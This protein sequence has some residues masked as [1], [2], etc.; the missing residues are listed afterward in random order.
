MDIKK[1]VEK[2]FRNF[3]NVG[4]VAASQYCDPYEYR[5]TLL[6]ICNPYDNE[7]LSLTITFHPEG[8]FISVEVGNYGRNLH[9]DR[10][11]KPLRNVV[12]DIQKALELGYLV[13]VGCAPGW[14]TQQQQWELDSAFDVVIADGI[15][16]VEHVSARDFTGI[17]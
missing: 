14:L 12:Q 13:P 9:L 1:W 10:V 5:A 15:G 2:V 8:G 16:G 3:S 7:L 6:N 17:E 11:E 4:L